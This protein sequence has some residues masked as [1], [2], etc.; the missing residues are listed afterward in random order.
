MIHV[1]VVSP[2]DVT[3]QLIPVL[4]SDSGV[5][6]LTVVAGSVRHPDGDAIR[7]DVLQGSANQVLARLRHSAST[8]GARS[9]WSRF[10][11]PSRRRRPGPRLGARMLRGFCA[12]MGGGRGSDPGG[13]ALSAELVRTAG[14]RRPD[15]GGGTVDQLADPHCRRHGGGTRVWGH[16]RSRLRPH[17][18][19][20]QAHDRQRASHGGRLY[21]SGDRG[22]AARPGDPRRRPAAQGIRAGHPAGQQ[23]HQH[24][25]LVLRHRGRTGRSR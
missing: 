20:C 24:P 9:Q 13:W 5:L 16:R 23:P 3:G 14:H 1:R 6:N 8:R 2:P 15:R 19:R 21:R 10:P 7:F 17:P 12:G 18:A 25:R 11:H 4:L 22:G